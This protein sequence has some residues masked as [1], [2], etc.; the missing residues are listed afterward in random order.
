MDFFFKKNE[1]LSCVSGKIIMMLI[2][3]KRKKQSFYKLTCETCY[4]A[5]LLMLIMFYQF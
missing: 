1:N 2:S 4:T 5:F 3:G